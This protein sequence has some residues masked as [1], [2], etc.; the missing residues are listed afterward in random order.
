MPARPLPFAPP[1]NATT[2][3]RRLTGFHVRQWLRPSGRLAQALERQLARLP[4]AD[5]WLAAWHG[6]LNAHWAFWGLFVSPLFVLS[7]VTTQLGG[8]GL[9][10]M[11]VV[12][13]IWMVFA[14]LL[15]W[16]SGAGHTGWGVTP[17]LYRVGMISFLL[18]L[19][20][21]LVGLALSSLA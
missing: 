8:I 18:P 12:S 2:Q 15:V 16:R 10:V 7:L 14:F 13:V 5:L 19:V 1:L 21:M 11:D 6:K 20:L 17:V 3:W 4:W 9:L